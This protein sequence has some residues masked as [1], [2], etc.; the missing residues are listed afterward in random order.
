MRTVNRAP[1]K[2]KII[3]ISFLVL[4]SC[5]M[6]SKE[7]IVLS[8]IRRVVLIIDH[9]AMPKDVANRDVACVMQYA[10]SQKVNEDLFLI[11]IYGGEIIFHNENN[12]PPGTKYPYSKGPNGKDE[13]GKGDD[14]A[15]SE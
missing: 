9:C 1:C 7:S 5:L 3:G 11:D 8:Q 14:I 4:T 2:L 10:K 12:C 6:T 13:C 15:S